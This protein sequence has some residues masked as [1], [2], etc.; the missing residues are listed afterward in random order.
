MGDDYALCFNSAAFVVIPSYRTCLLKCILSKGDTST[1]SGVTSN[2][3][4]FKVK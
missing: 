1:T 4:Q 3:G 2:Q